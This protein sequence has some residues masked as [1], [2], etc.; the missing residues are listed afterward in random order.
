LAIGPSPNDGNFTLYANL[1]EKAALDL[2][3]LDLQSARKI[4]LKYDSKLDSDH[5]AI[6]FRG[7]NLSEGVYALF[8]TANGDTK[9]VKF[10]VK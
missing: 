2:F 7:L 1:T 8:V 4:P 5:Y 6:P 9:Y 10:T 3:I